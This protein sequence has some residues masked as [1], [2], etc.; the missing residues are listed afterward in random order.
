MS[1]DDVEIDVEIDDG[2]AV[3]IGPEKKID[4]PKRKR[5]KYKEPSPAPQANG[6]L[7]LIVRIITATTLVYS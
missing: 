7:S 2:V 4:K 3:V 1:Q 6:S 5:G